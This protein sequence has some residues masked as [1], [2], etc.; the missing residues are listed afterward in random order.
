MPRPIHPP[1]LY[2]LVRLVRTWL[3]EKT[4]EE[5]TPNQV[6]QCLAGAYGIISGLG[7][8]NDEECAGIQDM[9]AKLSSNWK[10]STH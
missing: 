7:Q 8:V 9:A 3:E 4:G 2:E 10:R 1:E 5:P 6:A